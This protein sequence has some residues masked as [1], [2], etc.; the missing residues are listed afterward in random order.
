MKDTLVNLN[1]QFANNIENKVNEM[2][3]A[4]L[5]GINTVVKMLI[6]K[7][8]AQYHKLMAN[9]Y[10]HEF[11]SANTINRLGHRITAANKNMDSLDH[12]SVLDNLK[13]IETLINLLDLGD[14]KHLSKQ[15]IK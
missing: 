13:N 15:L 7:V 11:D 12:A 6:N 10:E 8:D 1:K 3:D 14:F 5:E 9:I 2:V 4:K